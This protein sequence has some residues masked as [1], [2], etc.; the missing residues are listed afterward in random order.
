MTTDENELFK[1]ISSGEHFHNFD[2]VA[3]QVGH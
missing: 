3:L 2:K 1:G